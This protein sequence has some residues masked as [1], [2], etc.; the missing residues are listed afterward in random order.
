[1]NVGKLVL[2]IALAVIAIVLGV[3]IYKEIQDPIDFN[4]AKKQRYAAAK[5][6]L[7][8]IK[9]A[10]FAYKDA[11]G[12]FANSWDQLINTIKYDSI[13]QVN[14]QGNPDDQAEDSTV[15]V[16]Y[17]TT[18]VSLLNETFGAG[19][20]I[21]DLRFVPF[22]NKDTFT[23]A[24]SELQL[25]HTSVP[26][27]EVSVSDEVLLNGLNEDFIEKDKSLTLGS[28]YE[29]TYNGNWE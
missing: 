27:F 11:K 20:D 7:M 24:S 28:L 26:V 9:K 6:K 29:A 25:A 21:D 8:D 1:M 19:Y 15:V 14:I 5:E 13:A 10:Q 16:I 4:K 17:D 12:K 2:N 22:T 23:I 3:L 18:M